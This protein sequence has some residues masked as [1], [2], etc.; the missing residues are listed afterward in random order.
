VITVGQSKPR[1][2]HTR[3]FRILVAGRL[4]EGFAAGLDAEITQEDSADGTLLIGELR[5]QSHLYGILDQL[6]QLGV[7]VL[8][9]ET[10]QAP[11]IGSQ[12]L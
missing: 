8:R 2:Q 1:D 9:F 11:E 4:G 10:F 3:R 5:D 7:D 12:S 6:R